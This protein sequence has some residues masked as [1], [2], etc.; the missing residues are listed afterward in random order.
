MHQL[1]PTPQRLAYPTPEAAQM[2]GISERGLW[3]LQDSG[4]I[5][6]IRIGRKVLYPHSELERFL[7]AKLQEAQEQRP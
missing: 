5:T 4:E 6:P 3:T 7:E 2:L 1:A